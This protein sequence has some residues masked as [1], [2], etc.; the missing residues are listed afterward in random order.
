MRTLSF[1]L[2]SFLLIGSLTSL[3]QQ[4]KLLYGKLVDENGIP[5]SN[6]SL[7]FFKDSS[8][9]AFKFCISDSKGQYNIALPLAY[10]RIESRGVG[11][12][13]FSTFIDISSFA[14][15]SI[16]LDIILK[17]NA[18]LLDDV[19]ITAKQPITENGD[20]TT[21][22]ASA[23]R[24]NRQENIE[25]LIKNMPGFTIKENGNIFFTGDTND[26]YQR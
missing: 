22:Q 1:F 21:F 13:S 24:N 16:L 3:A 2:C 11:Y 17:K 4:R 20:T 14:T 15:D 12:K 25:D 10:I 8:V 7:S 19:T 26:L 23:F 5:Q 6:I 9:T 18:K